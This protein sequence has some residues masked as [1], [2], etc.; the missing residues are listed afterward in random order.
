[1]T[2]RRPTVRNRVIAAAISAAME[3]NGWNG[4]TFAEI[5]DWSNSKVSRLATGTRHLNEQGVVMALAALRVTGARRDELFDLAANL[6]QDSWCQEH[7]QPFPNHQTLRVIEAAATR[8]ITYSTNLLPPLLQ[9][10]DYLR[11]LAT[12]WPT[13]DRD[14]Q[15]AAHQADAMAALTRA[16]RTTTFFIDEHAV[17]RRD[18][19]DQIMHSQVFH[20]LRIAL[21]S[22]IA[23]RIVPDTADIRPYSSFTLM[24]F[25]KY[26]PLVHVDHFLVSAFLE[27]TDTIAGYHRAVQDLDQHALTTTQT[28]AWL[29]EYAATLIT[30]SDRDDPEW[31]R[32]VTEMEKS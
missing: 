14:Q 3:N 15:T 1:M 31:E 30:T 26:R 19:P 28:D 17:I 23:I 29:R 10:T 8:I 2:D 25:P 7:G 16:Q 13:D 20:L 27:H 9:T 5:M 32:F 12:H 21:Q 22:G 6:D 11:Q 24:Y 4:L 18:L